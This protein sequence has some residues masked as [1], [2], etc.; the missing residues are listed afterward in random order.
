MDVDPPSD[1]VVLMDYLQLRVYDHDSWIERVVHW[2][3]HSDPG[4][5]RFGCCLCYFHGVL[6]RFYRDYLVR[7]AS[8]SDRA[9][10]VA[11]EQVDLM[12]WYYWSSW[13]SRYKFR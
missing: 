12:H 8:C 13:K 11:F 3:Q 5:A 1:L 7:E 10:L 6:H 2:S 9:C 4:W